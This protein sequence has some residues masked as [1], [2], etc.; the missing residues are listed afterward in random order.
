[1]A[2]QDWEFIDDMT[3]ENGDF[4]II[5]SDQQHI[6]HILKAQKGHFYEHPTLG[7]GIDDLLNSSETNARINQIITENLE[8]DDFVVKDILI[9]MIDN[10]K[11]VEI[12]AKRRK[13]V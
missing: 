13:Q 5:E 4:K 2:A 12:D 8:Q 6:E 7:A 9:S 10:E 1:M 11:T 3:I